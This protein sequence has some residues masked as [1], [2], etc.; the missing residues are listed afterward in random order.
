MYEDISGIGT[1]LPATGLTVAVGGYAFDV[2]A[3]LVVS[4]F[5]ILSGILVMR[6]SVRNRP[7]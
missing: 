1:A 2:F 5:L 4:F 7:E 6:L 3:L